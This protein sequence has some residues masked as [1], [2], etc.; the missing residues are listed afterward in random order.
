MNLVH[1]IARNNADTGFGPP[2]EEVARQIEEDQ[3]V[4][5][6]VLTALEIKPSA[7][8]HGRAR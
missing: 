8:K 5:E 7:V 1:R 3:D 4:L 2:L 6:A